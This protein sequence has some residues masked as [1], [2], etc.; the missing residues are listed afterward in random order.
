[1]LVG[2]VNALIRYQPFK[3]F[4]VLTI[5]NSLSKL[6]LMGKLLNYEENKESPQ[7]C[8]DS[9]LCNGQDQG[10]GVLLFSVG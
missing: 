5:L 7:I 2:L 6:G 4:A 3:I 9:A 1:M 10:G 8:L